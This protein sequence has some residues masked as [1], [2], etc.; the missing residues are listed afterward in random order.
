MTSEAKKKMQE[1]KEFLMTKKDDLGYGNG[2]AMHCI[3]LEQDG[4]IG[5][6]QTGGGDYEDCLLMLMYHIDTVREMSKDIIKTSGTIEFMAMLTDMYMNILAMSGGSLAKDG[7]SY[8][9]TMMPR[10]RNESDN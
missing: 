7:L 3:T 10:F 9:Q 2:F 4:R 8:T 1:F 6:F 5:V